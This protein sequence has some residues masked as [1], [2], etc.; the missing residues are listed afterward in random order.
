MID[1]R[2][3]ARTSI[4][5]VPAGQTAVLRKGESATLH[6]DGSVTIETPPSR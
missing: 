6:R 3:P 5:R 2:H 1:Y 4:R